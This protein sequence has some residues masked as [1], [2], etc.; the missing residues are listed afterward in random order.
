MKNFTK[1]SGRD[2]SKPVFV[3]DS[4]VAIKWLTQEEPF[5]KKACEVLEDYLL[6][7]IEVCIPDIFWWEI[8]NYFGREADSKT[9]STILMNLKKYRFATHM[10]TDGMSLTSFKIMNEAKGVSFYDAS[11][12]SLAI[13]MGGTFITSDKKY[14]EKAE[15]LGNICFLP[16]YR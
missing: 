7:K 16:N 13:Q 11:Y 6:G 8:G 12:H 1:S 10:L 5:Y 3:M 4:S 14:T 15:S 9:A 2:G